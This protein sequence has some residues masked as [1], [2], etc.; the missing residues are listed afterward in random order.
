M[1]KR[2][3][4]LVIVIILIAGLA[5]ASTFTLKDIEVNGC[6]MASEDEVRDTITENVIYPKLIG[7]IVLFILLLFLFLV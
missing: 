7:F 2:Y 4:L 1:K 5:Y 3:I 6:I